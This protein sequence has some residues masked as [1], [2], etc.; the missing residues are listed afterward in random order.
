MLAALGALLAAPAIAETRA[1]LIGVS[2]YASPAVPDLIGPSNDLAAMEALVRDMGVSDVVSLRDA[3]VSRSSVEA[4][5]QQIGLR[6]KPGDWI[7]LYYSGHGAQAAARTRSTS[8]GDYDQFVPLPGFDPAKQ[9]PERFIV[10][11]DFYAWLKRYAAPDVRI[12]MM[13]DSCHS[14]T[15]HRAVDPRAFNFTPRLAFRSGDTRA[16]ELVARPGPRLPGLQ[17]G[18]QNA[19]QIVERGDLPNLLYIGASRDDQLALETELPQEGAPQRGV[20]TFAFEQGLK[21]AGS[22]DAHAAADFDGDGKV[23]VLEISSYLSSQVRMLTAQRQESTSFFPSLWTDLPLFSKLPVPRPPLDDL[24][25]AVVFAGGS[26]APSTDQSRP[27]RIAASPENADFLWMTDD[28]EVVRRS[29]DVVASD[30]RSIDAFE[31]VIEKWRTVLALRPL[32]SELNLQ[33]AVA[34]DGSDTIYQK[35]M[36]VALKLARPVGAKRDPDSQYVTVFN[37]AADGTVQL[38]YPL[39]LDGEG[40]FSATAELTLFETSVVPPYGVDHVVAL[41][42]PSPPADLRAALRMMDGRRGSVP[43]VAFIRS[44]LKRS[45]GKGSLSIVELYTGP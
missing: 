19:D 8:D 10:D 38:L 39:A 35:D 34:P 27:W 22:D 18:P 20:L 6:A 31:G 36:I 2:R 41:G 15:M 16:I 17:T 33:M 23:T 9:D 28:G 13:V 43:F 14:G 37:L 21:S 42:T 44:E 24:P 3:A 11:K 32:V 30:I 26:V 7:L 1:L 45:K 29:G 4:A 40:R 5:L 12:L 25:P